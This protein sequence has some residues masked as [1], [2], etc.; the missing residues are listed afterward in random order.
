MFPWVLDFFYKKDFCVY[1]D[2]IT[3]IRNLQFHSHLTGQQLF[4]GLKEMVF[5]SI[6]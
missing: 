3:E 5:C 2:E 4:N 6:W 1:D